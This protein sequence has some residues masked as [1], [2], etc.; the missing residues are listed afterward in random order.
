MNRAVLLISVKV[1][2][3]GKKRF[4]RIILLESSREDNSLRL[5]GTQAVKIS[6][7]A[8][9]MAGYINHMAVLG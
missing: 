6:A 1:L 2:R 4:C 3:S 9:N 8:E 7:A 5:Q